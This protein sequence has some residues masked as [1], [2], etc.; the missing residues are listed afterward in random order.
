M[1][2][3]DKCG[4]LISDED[5]CLEEGNKVLCSNCA[6]NYKPSKEKLLTDIA[7]EAESIVK[8]ISKHKK[9][10]K[11]LSKYHEAY[12]SFDEDGVEEE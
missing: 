6:E 7:I 10:R 11:S 5:D 4:C 12:G 8:D 1:S 3:C 2:K 9:L